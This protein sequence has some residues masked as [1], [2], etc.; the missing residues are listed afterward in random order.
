M[1]TGISYSEVL[2]AEKAQ[3]SVD[4]SS[5][6][7]IEVLALKTKNAAIMN[8]WW[9]S[10]PVEDLF[11][12]AP[13]TFHLFSK[14]L[15][16]LRVKILNMALDD[17]PRRI[18]PVQPIRNYEKP[19]PPLF[20]ASYLTRLV[21]KSRYD[22]HNGEQGGKAFKIYIDFAK[23]SL[24]INSNFRVGGKRTP[25]DLHSTVWFDCQL[26][27]RVQRL[28]MSLLEMM[29]LIS[30]YR[31][32]KAGS[33]GIYDL[34]HMLETECPKLTNLWAVLNGPQPNCKNLKLKQFNRREKKYWNSPSSPALHIMDD[35]EELRWSF[36]IAQDEGM[37]K[38]LSLALTIDKESWS[39]VYGSVPHVS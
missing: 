4:T 2:N 24:H 19:S 32:N 34:W 15:V 31:L 10:F 8:E 35:W 23:D 14:L 28:I 25:S 13:R 37:C 7:S 16:E 33:V 9:S 21:A 30:S 39:R 38:G 3:A 5:R 17:I 11:E 29:K 22:I 36:L 26:L 1:D 12:G 6:S 20:R 27:I 18:I